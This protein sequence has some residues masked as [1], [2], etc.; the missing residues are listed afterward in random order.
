VIDVNGQN[1]NQPS[2]DNQNKPDYSHKNRQEGKR[3]RENEDARPEKPTRKNRFSTKRKTRKKY[4]RKQPTQTERKRCDESYV[5]E[6]HEK[7]DDIKALLLSPNHEDRD[8][9]MRAVVETFTSSVAG[10]LRESFKSGLPAYKLADIWQETLD[11]LRRNVEEGKFSPKG[12]LE[13]YLCRIARCRAIDWLRKKRRRRVVSL[14]ALQAQDALGETLTVS[15]EEGQ[16]RPFDVNDPQTRI[17][18]TRIRAAILALSPKL[19]ESMIVDLL[20]LDEFGDFCS[21]KE[22]ARLINERNP[23]SPPLKPKGAASRRSRALKL[24]RLILERFFCEN[25]RD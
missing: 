2:D 9:G 10:Y 5:P 14:D 15:P 20:Y 6:R 25:E 13:S 3:N 18:V 4:K 22:L 21:S 8:E 23:D 1:D 24:L 16:A 17:L 7:E 11:N 12:N 19:Q